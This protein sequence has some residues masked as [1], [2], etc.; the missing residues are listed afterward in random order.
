V[1]GCVVNVN[2]SF[3]TANSS[4]H[5]VRGKQNN[6]YAKLTRMVTPWNTATRGA[7]VNTTSWGDL[8]SCWDCHAL[9]SET[10]TIQGTVTAHGGA[11]T[12]RGRATATGTTLNATTNSVTLCNVCHARYNTCG[13][14]TD[15]CGSTYSHGANSA[16]A[17][18]TGR[19]TKQNYLR[20]G[21]NLCHASGYRTA[22]IVARPV[23][24]QD[25][26][27]VNALPTY[28]TGAV[29]KS[30]RWTSANPRP[31]AFIRNIDTLGDHSPSSWP[32]GSAAQPSCDMLGSGT[33]G[34][35]CNQGQENLSPG[36]T[37]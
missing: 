31:Y 21:C 17:T 30:G 11:E 16:F 5:P 35:S 32:G 9:P 24:A 29:T 23:R 8:M 27:G 1:D 15:A 13:G 12:L 4:Y 20:Y 3:D 26:H 6:W 10:G 14:A 7:T 18:S 37:F 34:P 22:T 19:S 28:T 36:G 25:S 33:G 2:D